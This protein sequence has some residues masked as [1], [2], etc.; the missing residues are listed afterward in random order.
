VAIVD[1]EAAY[2]NRKRVPEHPALIVGWR[3]DA[4]VFRDGA[5]AELDIGYGRTE[6]T[7]LDIFRPEGAGEVPLAIFF[8]GGYWRTFD[9]SLFSHA[10]RGLVRHGIAVAIPSYN[11]CPSVSVGTIIDEARQAVAFLYRQHGRRMFA[12]GHSAGGHLAAA[13]LATDWPA[14][15]PDLPRDT[16]ASALGISGLFDLEPL[17]STS[18]NADLRMSAEEARQW[19]PLGWPAPHGLVL[20]AYVGGLESSE[21]LRQ[22]RTVT[23]L[24]GAAGA[25]TRYAEIDGA[26]HFTALAPFTDPDTPETARMVEMVRAIG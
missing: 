9:R 12:F 20:D 7:R 26:N 21:Y 1:F 15:A 10:A 8:H 23:D 5:R 13:M 4:A 16:V 24:W 22:A 17:L 2:D 3:R 11:L 25:L 19:S 18:I 14:Y 6:R